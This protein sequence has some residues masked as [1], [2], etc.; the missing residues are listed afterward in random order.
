ML[1][2]AL[3]ASRRVDESREVL[4]MLPVTSRSELVWT[5]LIGVLRAG[6]SGN[7]QCVWYGDLGTGPRLPGPR[8]PAGEA[9]ASISPSTS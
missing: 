5:D 6:V 8:L 1:R 2:V 7:L 4:P 9:G 3:R